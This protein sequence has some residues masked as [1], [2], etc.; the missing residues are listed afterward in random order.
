MIMLT[1]CLKLLQQWWGWVDGICY[2]ALMLNLS[3]CTALALLKMAK[4]PTLMVCSDWADFER[5]QWH[6]YKVIAKTQICQG[7]VNEKYLNSSENLKS[8]ERWVLRWSWCLDVVESKE[9]QMIV[10]V[11]LELLI[12]SRE[13]TGKELFWVKETGKLDYLVK[14]EFLVVSIFSV[15]VY[16]H[17]AAR[18]PLK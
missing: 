15:C 10:V 16:I 4:N 9:E 5:F 14:V 13:V 3:M 18:S 17:A 12:G 7:D 2:T 1:Y 8:L 11:C 6:N